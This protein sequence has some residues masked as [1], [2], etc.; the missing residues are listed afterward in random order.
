MSKRRR[1]KQSAPNIPEETLQRAREQAGLEP[2]SEAAETLDE[3]NVTPVAPASESAPSSRRTRRNRR[4]NLNPAQIEKRKNRD[5]LDGDMIADALAN[6]TKFVSEEELREE[7]TYVLR[8]L[9]GMGILAAIL[10]V[11]LIIM[12]QFIS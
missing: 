5:D 10:F 12:A 6:P 1:R 4:S 9:R 11:F 3:E 8:D 7:Y 2:T